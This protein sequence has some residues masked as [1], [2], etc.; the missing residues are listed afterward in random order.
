MMNKTIYGLNR[1]DFEIPFYKK[2]RLSDYVIWCISRDISDFHLDMIEEGF[3]DKWNC[4]TGKLIGDGDMKNY[5]YHYLESL[6]LKDYPP[7][8]LVD[9]AIDLMLDYMAKIGEWRLDFGEN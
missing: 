6:K 9:E 4:S 8:A 5:V 3:L 1:Q 2:I 7:Q